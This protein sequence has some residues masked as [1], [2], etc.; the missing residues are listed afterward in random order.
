[1][2]WTYHALDSLRNLAHCQ[3]KDQADGFAILIL[4]LHR[5]EQGTSFLFVDTLL[6]TRVAGDLAVLVDNA[7]AD[8]LVAIFHQFFDEPF[9]S[10]LGIVILYSQVE[11][12]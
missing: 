8:N 7:E 10:E 6:D 1:M 12:A 4:S 11:L 3:F 5:F 9:K 2:R